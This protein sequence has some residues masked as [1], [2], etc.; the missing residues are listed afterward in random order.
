MEVK[1]PAGA[2]AL[3]EGVGRAVRGLE[4]QVLAAEIEVRVPR[5]RVG[6]L[7]NQ[8]GIARGC[9]I[10]RRL[11]IRGRVVP[12]G[13]RRRVRTCEGNV[14]GGRRKNRGK[15]CQQRRTDQPLTPQRHAVSLGQWPTRVNWIRQEMRSE[16]LMETE[17][18]HRP[19][20]TSGL[21]GMTTHW[22]LETVVPRMSQSSPQ[23]CE[24]VPP[25]EHQ[26]RD[27]LDAV[28]RSASIGAAG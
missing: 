6:S 21:L 1:A 5:P 11:D 14:I 16:L 13:E 25:I 18:P 19:V 24:D 15:P 17:I 22:L 26:E 4:H 27:G 23:Q 2:G 8:Y 9:G 28:R 12:I 7:A 3:D 20:A 10:K